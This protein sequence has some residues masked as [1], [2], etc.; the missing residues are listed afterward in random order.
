MPLHAINDH[1]CGQDTICLLIDYRFVL[2]EGTG[3]E[4]VFLIRSILIG[5]RCH[6]ALG[7]P[8]YSQTSNP[9]HS[10]FTMAACR[11]DMCILGPDTVSILSIF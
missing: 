8:P 3:E 7:Q 6:D 9:S 2:K 1:I 11:K 5:Y 4:P 10:V